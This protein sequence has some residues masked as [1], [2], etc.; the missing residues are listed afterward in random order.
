[1]NV[2][3]DANLVFY[4]T[5]AEIES[6]KNLI[7]NSKYSKFDIKKTEA[8]TIESYD[9]NFNVGTMSSLKFNSKYSDF[10]SQANL[11]EIK[12]DLYDCNITVNS[13]ERV[14]FN[15]KYCDL[16]LGNTGEFKTDDSYD[17]DIHLGNT[18]RVEIAKSKYSLFEIASATNI[19]L[20][21]VYDDIV[22]IGKLNPD[23]SELSMNGKYGKL[24]VEAGST[25]FKVQF[26]IK[27]PKVDIPESVKITKKISENS[28]M[29]LVGGETGGTFKVEGYDMKVV[30]ND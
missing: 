17:N 15:G 16:N 30:I 7:V 8:V 18:K 27:Y 6:C 10:V 3:Q 14:L 21:D 22:K 29:E 5:D 25:P 1:V 20:I 9:D 19:K 12:L 4:D 2:L 26:K 11:K 24:E 28:D 23:F 13:A